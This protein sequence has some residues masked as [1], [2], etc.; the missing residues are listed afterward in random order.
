MT[1]MINNSFITLSVIK[2]ATPCR[3]PF[4]EINNNY[5]N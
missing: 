4:I 5:N 3:S 1:A 2:Q